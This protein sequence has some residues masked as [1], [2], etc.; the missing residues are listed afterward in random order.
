[1]RVFISY[2]QEDRVQADHL[3]QRL[4]DL[5]HT[6]WS[7]SGLHGG[8]A[9]WDEILDRIRGSDALLLLI[10]PAFLASQACLLERRY[11]SLLGKHLVPVMVAPVPHHVLPTELAPLQIVDYV[12]PGEAAAYAFARAAATIQPSRGLPHPL[13]PP[14]PVPLSYLN[15]V[16]DRM[17]RPSLTMDEQLEIIE[18][19]GR[20]AR[21]EDSE[22]RRA[23]H[24]L[25]QMLSRRTDLYES[26]SRRL[27][28]HLMSGQYVAPAPRPAHV[29]TS[30]PAK[31]TPT[32]VKV[33]AWIGAI[34]VALILLIWLL[35]PSESQCFSDSL[36]YIWCS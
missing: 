24:D 32:A 7:D 2:A 9:W 8:Q 26:A 20:G 19:L 25:L 6:P 33:L 28:E 23:A 21:A 16:R 13:P 27:H 1:M 5:G 31:G 36:G 4:L 15:G 10:S 34:F 12:H 14:P 30:P 11:A 17:G 3:K 18:L 29:P 22:E 35:A